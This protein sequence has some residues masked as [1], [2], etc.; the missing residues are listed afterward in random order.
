[1]AGT[2]IDGGLDGGSPGSGSPIGINPGFV[3]RPPP[4]D[5]DFADLVALMDG[6]VQA[7]LGDGAVTYRPGVQGVDPVQVAGTFDASYK[8]VSSGGDEAGV[9]TVTPAVF[10]QL[11]D[12][13]TDPMIDSPTLVIRGLTYK[14]TGRHPDDFGSILLTLRQVI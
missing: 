1:M 4:P 13:P 14:V 9:E 11:A 5:T 12:L 8:L 7:V 3:P 6:T 10:L 2:G